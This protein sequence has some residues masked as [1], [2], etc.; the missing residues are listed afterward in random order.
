MVWLDSVVRPIKGLVQPCCTSGVQQVQEV[1]R[2]TK[3]TAQC[4]EV[5][6]GLVNMGLIRSS[7]TV[8]GSAELWVE[9]EIQ[10]VVF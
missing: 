8:P 9:V 4:R 7:L 3:N 1:S 2:D 6:R 5:D 10:E